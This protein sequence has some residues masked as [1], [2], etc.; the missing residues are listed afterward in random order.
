LRID[1]PQ[2]NREGSV[3]ISAIICGDMR[4]LEAALAET[5]RQSLQGT[6][7]GEVGLGYHPRSF[8]SIDICD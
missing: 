7:H 4:G 5:G 6:I 1:C 2:D 3:R 8:V